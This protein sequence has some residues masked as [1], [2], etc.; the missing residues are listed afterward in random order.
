M[1][2]NQPTNTPTPSWR[3]LRRQERDQRYAFRAEM[4]ARGR[5]W[6][7]NNAWIVGAVLTLVGLLMMMENLGPYRFHNWWALFILIPAA[8][9]FMGAWRIFTLNG[10]LMS[11]LVAGPL[12][13][14]LILTAITATILFDLNWG[15]VG[16]VLLIILGLSAL[17]GAFAWRNGGA[18]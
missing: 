18:R 8:G 13:T 14:G 9:A 5:V 11:M 10:S 17:F 15:I 2:E 12:L 4:R 6:R 3:E 16:P 1:K 7:G